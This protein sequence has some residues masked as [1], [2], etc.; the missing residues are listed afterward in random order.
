M[1]GEDRLIEACHRSFAWLW[2]DRAISYRAERGITSISLNPDTVIQTTHTI[3]EA[4]AELS[5]DG[6]AQPTAER[7]AMFSQMDASVKK[8]V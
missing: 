1:R 6:Y 8:R 4:E 7:G 5:P 3:G 2:T